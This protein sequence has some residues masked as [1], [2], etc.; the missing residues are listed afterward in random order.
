VRSAA[1]ILAATRRLGIAALSLHARVAR[2]SG[3][4]HEL[5]ER[6]AGDVDAALGAIVAALHDGT[7]APA[8]P[9]LRAHQIALERSLDEGGD[10]AVEVLVSETDL[11]VDGID[12]IAAVLS[13]T[14]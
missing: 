1:G 12:T 8:L 14:R 5:I 2:I 4:P 11:V 9:P 6:F 3:A 13:R 10:P 7:T